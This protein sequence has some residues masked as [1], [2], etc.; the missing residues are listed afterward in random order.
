MYDDFRTK[1]TSLWSYANNSKSTQGTGCSYYLD[2]HSMADATLSNGAGF[3]LV[4][5]MSNMPCHWNSSEC[6]GC[7]MASAHLSSKQAHSF[8]DFELRMRAPHNTG[9]N[10]TIW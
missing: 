3:G 1:N 9:K 6:D 7:A 2:N 10:P 4:M 5:N 8:G